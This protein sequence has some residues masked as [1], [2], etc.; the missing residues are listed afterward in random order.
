MSEYGQY[1]SALIIAAD[2]YRTENDVTRDEAPHILLRRKFTLDYNRP[3][4]VNVVF[5]LLGDSEASEGLFHRHRS[6]GL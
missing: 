2:L 1:V 4:V 6:C 3:R 5:F